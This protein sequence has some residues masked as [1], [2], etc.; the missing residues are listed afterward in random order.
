MRER[1]RVLHAVVLP[2]DF[3]LFC[4]VGQKAWSAQNVAVANFYW[5]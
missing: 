3:T 5:T 2:I 4:D 1:S